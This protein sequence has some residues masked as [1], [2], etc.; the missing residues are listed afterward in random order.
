[1]V[2]DKEKDLMGRRDELDRHLA[3]SPAMLFFMDRDGV[4]YYISPSVGKYLGEDYKNI[5]GKRWKETDLPEGLYGMFEGHLRSTLKTGEGSREE[6]RL[7]TLLGPRWLQYDISP[8]YDAK[9]R[10]DG[11]VAT[12]FDV[13]ER[14]NAEDSLKGSEERL[15]TLV[16][17]A[18]EGIVINISGNIVE[19]NKAMLDMTG[20]AREEVLGRNILD[21]F[22][23]GS[24]SLVE[25]KLSELSAGPYEAQI[26]KKDRSLLTVQIRGRTIGW[27]GKKAR[28][29]AVQD[30][31]EL[32]MVQNEL[33]KKATDL[34]RSN[35]DLQRFAYVASHD[36]KEPLRMVVSYLN[37]LNDRNKYELDSTSKE[38]IHFA[39]DGA[40]RMRAM[41]DDL[42]SY[43]KVGSEIMSLTIVNMEDVLSTV[44]KDLVVSIRETKA[45]ITHDPLP[46]VCAVRSQMV[47]LLENLIGNAIKYHGK[48][49]PM[50]HISSREGPEERTFSVKDNG[51]G[52]DPKDQGR[53]FNMFQRLGPRGEQE[54]TG[55]GLAISKK[56][57]ERHGGRIWI[58]SGTE[59]GSIFYFTIPI[60]EPGACTE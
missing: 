31:T 37:L 33:A 59:G 22:T 38:Y 5:V 58:G 1:M 46:K 56:I 18:F 8:S 43:S 41:I 57:I 7:N 48:A 53:L 3:T 29:G 20:Y 10:I 47:L 45:V 6:I 42:L 60:R 28:L 23:M 17:A 49:E 32:K 24:R 54:G 11:A 15:K 51:I 14:R 35:S 36:L 4:I 34:E 55:M 30:I 40:L 2:D 26:I 21:Y 13:T 19:V 16:A 52:I 12:I 44:I 27:N 39:M 25:E 50:I 9:N